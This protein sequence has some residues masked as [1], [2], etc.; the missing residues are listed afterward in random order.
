VVDK[1]WRQLSPDERLERRFAGL[2][3]P[4]LEF[5]SSEAAAEYRARATR[6]KAALLL[7]GEPDRVPV[8][9]LTGY[10]PA[11]RKGLTPYD[12]TQDYG[13]A[14]D[15]WYEFN[16][17]VQPDC[18]SAPMFAAIP[19]RAF[20]AIDTQILKWPGHGVAKEASFQYTEQEWMAED[21][22]DLLIDD[23]TDFLLHYYLP[24]VATGLSGFA[25]LASPLDMIE[26]VAGPSWMMRWADPD[27]QASLAA[28]AKAGQEC[29]AWGGAMYPLVG[30][31]IADGF[32]GTFA[33]MSKAPFDVIGDTL[34]GIRGVLMDMFRRPDELLE[35]CDRLAPVMVKWVTRRANPHTAPLVFMPLHKG[36]DSFMS[37]DQF[38]KFYWPTLLKVINGLVADGFVPYLF[39]EGAYGTRLE[40]MAADLPK[41]RTVWQFDRTDMKRAKQILG[42][43][44]CIQ[45]NVPLSLLQLGTA[46]QVTAYCRDLIENVAP[47]GGFIL[48]VGAVLDEAKPGNVEAM[49]QAARDSAR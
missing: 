7:E 29:A 16:H 37:L 9:L 3:E 20:E 47:G 44:A 33:M 35:A 18:L 22:Y 28:L 26:I 25:K 48:D 1:E 41:G 13:K 11:T 49:V 27:V 46:E 38:Q 43:T 24:R 4:G 21:E 23:P 2:V 8:A 19:G 34:R 32:P 40:T 36:A 42:G 12:V 5:A 45:G 14:V 31:L 15:A 10:Y 6:L 39:A 30:R 17:D